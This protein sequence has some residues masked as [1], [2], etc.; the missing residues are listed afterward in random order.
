MRFKLKKIQKIVTKIHT[1]ILLGYQDIVRPKMALL[2][3]I[4]N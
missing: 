4:E 3:L 2:Y 1:E